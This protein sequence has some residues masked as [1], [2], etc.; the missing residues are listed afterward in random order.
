MAGWKWQYSRKVSWCTVVATNGALSQSGSLPFRTLTS[1]PCP[2]AGPTCLSARLR[3]GGL[4][5]H[6]CPCNAPSLDLTTGHRDEL[7]LPTT[8]DLTSRHSIVLGLRGW[9]PTLHPS[10]LRIARDYIL[11]ASQLDKLNSLLSRPKL[12]S[13]MSFLHCSAVANVLHEVTCVLLKR[14]QEQYHAFLPSVQ[15]IS[16]EE[17]GRLLTV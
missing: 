2:T 8:P 16:V 10:L 14:M 11:A 17:D 15:E 6:P 1:V 7:L 5:C 13:R 9:Q 4:A 12:E 3:L